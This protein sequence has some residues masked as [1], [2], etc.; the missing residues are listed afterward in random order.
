MKKILYLLLA[1]GLLY[2][3]KKDN[4]GA[5]PLLYFKSY[6]PDSITP[7]TQQFILTMRVEDGDGDIEDSIGV[8]MLKDSEQAVNKD[9]I[10]QFYK[11]PK[12]GQNRGNSVKA[13]VIMPFGEI[14]FAAAYN[15][16]PGDSAHYIVFLRDNSGNISDTVPTPKFPFRRNR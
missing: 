9:T 11:M 6:Q 2:A 10:W 13:D 12:I 8:A 5:K 14:D 7:E 3:C 4:V 1:V 15:P 16:A